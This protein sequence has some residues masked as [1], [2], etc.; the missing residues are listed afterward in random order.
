[1]RARTR[2]KPR[3][4][5]TEETMAGNDAFMAGDIGRNAPSVNSDGQFAMVKSLAAAVAAEYR[6]VNVCRSCFCRADGIVITTV[7]ADSPFLLARR[8]LPWLARRS[9]W[10]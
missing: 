6:V 9:K 7:G 1:M 2:R 3:R 5:H 4:R 8:P 10:E